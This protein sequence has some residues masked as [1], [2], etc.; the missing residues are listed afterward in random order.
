M[1]G[2][3][4]GAAA[5]CCI[6]LAVR[7]IVLLRRP[8]AVGRLQLAP[9]LDPRARRSGPTRALVDALGRRLGPT[10]L[11]RMGERRRESIQRRLD[12]AGRPGGMHLGRYAEIQATILTVAVVLAGLFALLGS[13]RESVLI[14][15]LGVFALDLWLRRTGRKRQDQIERDLPDFVDILAVTVRAGVGYRSA[16]ERVSRS[17]S[18][19]ASEEIQQALREMELGATRREAFMDL[20]DRNASPTL[21]SFV[22][23]QLQAE[24]LGVPLADALEAIAADT[25]RAA[26]QAARR[27]AQ[28]TTPRITL[29]SAVVLLPATL[30][31]LIGG[32]VFGSGISFSGVLG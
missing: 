30:L 25:R 4:T 8:T 32:L 28:R 13:L 24:E 6:A 21:D 10:L 20:R 11:A 23:A 16:L 18:G 2:E 12:L 1:I 7:A 26:A 22:T 5:V 19:P 27:R 3:L 17:L 15:V 9:E 31:L 14:L 29:I